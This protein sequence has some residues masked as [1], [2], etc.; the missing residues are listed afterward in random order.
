MQDLVPAQ[1]LC[2]R[3]Q[4]LLAVA[5]VVFMHASQLLRAL[6]SPT[7]SLD[8]LPTHGADAATQQQ[9]QRPSRLTL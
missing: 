4:D 5:F 6:H 2:R 9:R 7:D 1:G 8:I 3:L